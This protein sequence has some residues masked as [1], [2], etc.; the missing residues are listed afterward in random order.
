MK[1]LATILTITICISLNAQP[2]LTDANTNPIIGDK[3]AY[4]I[5]SNIIGPG[6]SGANQV[7]NFSSMNSFTMDSINMI[8]PPSY[9]SNSSNIEA[10]SISGACYCTPYYPN[11]SFSP[12]NAAFYNTSTLKWQSGGVQEIGAGLT[13][14]YSDL[15][16]LLHYPFT[17]NDSFSDVFSGS[18]Y[19]QTVGFPIRYVKGKDSVAADG[20]GTLILPTGTY[21][22]VLRVHI[23][24]F[25]KDS[26]NVSNFNNTVNE[27]YLWFLPGNHI[28]IASHTSY[29]GQ[30]LCGYL[31][32]VFMTDI[33]QHAVDDKQTIIS[34]N[35]SN[36]IFSIS[37][38]SEV[39]QSQIEVFN[40]IGE[41]ILRQIVTSANSQID[42]SSQP[43]GVYFINISMGSKQYTQKVIKN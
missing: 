20:Y 36:G 10:W 34:P 2:V 42:L 24:E 41:C 18:Y 28:P 7:W 13:I 23:L 19:T 33:E 40:I 29:G 1:K 43:G 8:S 31:S 6:N 25:I 35:P 17:F 37:V 12:I 11:P 3:F 30:I 26:Q 5:S 15:E 38:I 22:N 14:Q 9:I 21:S 4:I 27:F 16:D 32:N 39:K